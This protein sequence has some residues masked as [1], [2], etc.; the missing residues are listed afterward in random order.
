MKYVEGGEKFVWIF[1]GEKHQYFLRQNTFEVVWF[2]FLRGKYCCKSNNWDITDL[3]MCESRSCSS[4]GVWGCVRGWEEAEISEEAGG[5]DRFHS[6]LI[7][8]NKNMRK[9][10]ATFIHSALNLKS[11]SEK[12][13]RR[14]PLCVCCC[15]PAC[16]PACLPEH[17]VAPVAYQF[18]AWYSLERKRN[19]PKGAE[20]ILQ[21]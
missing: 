2:K 18:I 7:P 3:W 19:A 17:N 8:T 4:I 16:L 21:T 5:T 12:M 10:L 13:L 11:P 6:R 14:F 15:L 20:Y 1:P 9:V